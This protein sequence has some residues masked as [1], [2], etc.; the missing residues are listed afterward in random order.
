MPGAYAMQQP[1]M[2]MHGQHGSPA[3][4]RV[5]GMVTLLHAAVSYGVERRPSGATSYSL[6]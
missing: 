5:P 6:K 1:T 4:Q 2:S 3:Q